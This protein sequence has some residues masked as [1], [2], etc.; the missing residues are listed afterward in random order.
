[1]ANF[2]PIINV[3]D[4]GLCIPE[5]G[6]WGIRKYQLLGGYC[7]IFTT[8]MKYHWKQLVYIDLF[9]GAGYAKIKGEEKIIK[10][11]PLIASETPT[12]FTKYILCEADQIKIEALKKRFFREPHELF[13]NAYFLQGDSNQNI[14]KIV[15]EIPRNND[16]LGFCFVDPFSLNLEFQTIKKIAGTGR[17]DFLILLALPMDGKRNFHNYI[18][19]E[20]KK[21]DRF[22]DN[23]NWREPFEKG[24]IP[25]Q[26]FMK[27]LADSFD[28]NMKSLGYVVDTRL[29]Y[30]VKT[31][32]N[33][34]PLY[35]LAFYSKHERGNDFYKKIEKYLRS[36]ELF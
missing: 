22:I 2:N 11:S 14:D 15:K 31:H 7:D 35:Y 23:N 28:K 1:M 3:N 17:V 5:I 21:I 9:A 26:N 13:K 24:L 16:V 18:Q 27:F 33:N 25:Q 30:Q 10:T 19:K 4:D 32:D 36:P 34:L 6:N 20:S 29:K 8:G 12:K